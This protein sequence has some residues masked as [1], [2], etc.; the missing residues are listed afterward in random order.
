M[1]VIEIQEDRNPLHI[2]GHPPFRGLI[3]IRPNC[4]LRGNRYFEALCQWRPNVIG[5]LAMAVT[6]PDTASSDGSKA[7]SQEAGVAYPY[8]TELEYGTPQPPFNVSPSAAG[9]GRESTH[10]A[11]KI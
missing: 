1:E 10:P 7:A 2:S 8:A 9:D 4:L 5:E 11:W 3:A 6:T